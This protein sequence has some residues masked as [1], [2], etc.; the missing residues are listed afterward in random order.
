MNWVSLNLDKTVSGFVAGFS[1]GLCEI[2]VS[3][4][5]SVATVFDMIETAQRVSRFEQ[6]L[7]TG[8]LGWNGRLSGALEPAQSVARLPAS[9][10][11]PT[12]TESCNR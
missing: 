2:T 9:Q 10:T 8:R 7:T 1:R 5:N 4:R 11:R 12:E 3:R 6:I